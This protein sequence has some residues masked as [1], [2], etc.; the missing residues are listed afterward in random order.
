MLGDFNAHVGSREQSGDQWSNLRG[1]H[2][3][4]DVNDASRELF[5]ALNEAMI[6]NTWYMKKSIHKA[7]WQRPRS[8]QWHYI[9][10]KQKDRGMCLGVSVKRGAECNTDHHFLCYFEEEMETFKT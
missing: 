10:M 6:C 2:G 9:K 4:D 3:Y 5:L 7:T 1:P 8:K